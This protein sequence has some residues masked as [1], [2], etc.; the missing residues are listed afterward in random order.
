MR[1]IRTR[2][3][4]RDLALSRCYKALGREPSARG[5]VHGRHRLAAIW[6]RNFFVAE[7]YVVRTT[8]AGVK[9]SANRWVTN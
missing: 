9:A 5:K 2:Q 3:I 8:A 1:A 6:R 7:R 4:G